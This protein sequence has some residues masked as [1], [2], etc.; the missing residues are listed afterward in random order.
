MAV[1][2]PGECVGLPF[3]C[4]EPGGASHAAGLVKVGFDFRLVGLWWNIGE[5]QGL[6]WVVYNRAWYILTLSCWKIIQG[7][8]EIDGSLKSLY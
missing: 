6:N 4:F 1:A 7:G 8:R 2:L 3:W 5:L